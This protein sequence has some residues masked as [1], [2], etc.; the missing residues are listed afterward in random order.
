MCYFGGQRGRPEKTWKEV[1]NEDVNDLN[2]K[3][4]DAV[5]CSKNCEMINRNRVTVTVTVTMS[6]SDS[7]SGSD[8]ESNINSNSDSDSNSGSNSDSDNE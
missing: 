6:N 3:P 1:V 2:I 8:S 5:D 4:S 7:N